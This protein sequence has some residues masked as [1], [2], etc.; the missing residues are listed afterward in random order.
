M[1]IFKGLWFSKKKSSTKGYSVPSLAAGRTRVRRGEGL[2]RSQGRWT[3]PQGT[4]KSPSPPPPFSLLPTGE[5]VASHL[6]SRTRRFEEGPPS[7]S[8]RSVGG[9]SDHG[10]GQPGGIRPLRSNHRARD[11]RIQHG[12]KLKRS[13]PSQG[14]DI[15]KALR[16]EGV[17]PPPRALP[18]TP[19]RSQCRWSGGQ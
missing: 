1:R 18:H 9:Y 17:L 10:M 4:R 8:W 5:A 12:R 16:S 15:S 6:P 11:L 14:S 13:K 3:R 19:S 2:G 7:G